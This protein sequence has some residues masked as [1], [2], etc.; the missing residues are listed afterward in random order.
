MPEQTLLRHI[1]EGLVRAMRHIYA[2]RQIELTI[3]DFPASLNFRGEAQD[4][5]EMLGKWRPDRA[6]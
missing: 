1:I 2:E 5:Q 3:R 4:L 6:R